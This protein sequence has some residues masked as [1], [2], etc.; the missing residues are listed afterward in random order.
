MTLATKRGLD[1]E[2]R[3]ARDTGGLLWSGTDGDVEIPGTDL[4]IECKYSLGFR[5]TR[6]KEWHDQVSRYETKKS[7]K[8]FVLAYTG[9]R[10]YQ[11]SRVWYSVPSELFLEFISFLRWKTS[12]GTISK[13]ASTLL[14]Q[15]IEQELHIGKAKS[16]GT[17]FTSDRNIGE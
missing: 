4:R 2:K 13:R 16:N 17:T 10:E 5:N 6:F 3:V 15:L 1:F 8:R 9:G 7:G 11:N 12:L 14:E